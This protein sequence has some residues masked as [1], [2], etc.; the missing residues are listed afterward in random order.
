MEYIECAFKGISPSTGEMLVALL[1]NMAFDTFHEE[2]GQLMA[3]IAEADWNTEV[4][5]EMEAISAQFGCQFS[6]VHIAD[7]NWNEEWEKNFPHIVVDEECLIRAPFHHIDKKYP[8][9]ITIEPRMSFGTGHHASTF[10]MIRRMLQMDF[11]GKKVCDAGSGTGILAIMAVMLGADHVFALD[12][13]EW[14]FNN[15]LDNIAMNGVADKVHIELGEMEMLEVKR[16]DVLLANINRNVLVQYMPQL[17]LALE[18]QGELV[19]SGVLTADMQHILDAAAAQ[20]LQL[21][22]HLQL[23][24]W[25]CAAFS[26]P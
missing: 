26:H 12:N 1:S 22:Q 16:F 13:N 9:T 2:D 6:Y 10:L 19:L 11:K 24:E 18:Q 21:T 7:K 23:E 17:E 14:A 20:G 3:Y 4:Q 25:S 15:S 8:Y 5:A